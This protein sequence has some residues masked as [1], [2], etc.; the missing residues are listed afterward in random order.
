MCCDHDHGLLYSFQ[1]LIFGLVLL[2]FGDG[3]VGDACF[4]RFIFSPYLWSFLH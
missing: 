4:N 1:C 2:I 3:Y